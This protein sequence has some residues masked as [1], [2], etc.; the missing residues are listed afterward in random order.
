M[1]IPALLGE[2]GRHLFLE[3]TSTK[4]LWGDGK[5]PFPSEEET[6]LD[7]PSGLITVS[8]LSQGWIS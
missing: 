8:F 4:S 5:V 6:L 2:A 1:E 3:S 7:L